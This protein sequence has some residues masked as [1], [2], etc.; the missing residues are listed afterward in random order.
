MPEFVPELGAGFDKDDVAAG[1]ASAEVDEASSI[2]SVEVSTQSVVDSSH[3]VSPDLCCSPLLDLDGLCHC[4]AYSPGHVLVQVPS[5]GQSFPP[6]RNPCFR[7]LYIDDALLASTIRLDSDCVPL[8]PTYG[9]LGRLAGCG[10]GVPGAQL[11]LEHRLR[12]VN[13]NAKAIGMQL[14][15]KKTNLIIFNK[16]KHYSVVY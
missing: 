13:A 8:L 15:V 2:D 1:G 10:L 11:Q 4:G 9:P 7:V 5:R 6:C 14:N 3:N 12:D 16:K